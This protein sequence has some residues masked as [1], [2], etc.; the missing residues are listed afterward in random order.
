MIAIIS[1][2]PEIAPRCNT[3]S[4]RLDGGIVCN[5]GKSLRGVVGSRD[6]AGLAGG[7]RQTLELDVLALSLSL[8]LGSSVGLDTVQ[9]VCSRGETDS[10][11]HFRRLLNLALLTIT[12]LGVL[13]VLNTEV[14]A[15]LHVAV[16]DD[17]VDNDTDRRRGDVVD[18]TGT[19]E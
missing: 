2:S 10:I 15:L 19:S 13:D 17:L 3:T 11:N 14:D 16:A 7:D 1:N 9:E 5:G 6:E 4:H 18:D 12:A 8:L